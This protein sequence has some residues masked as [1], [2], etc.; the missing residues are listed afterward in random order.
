MIVLGWLICILASLRWRCENFLAQTPQIKC[1]TPN[2]IVKISRT[3]AKYVHH[4]LENETVQLL[5][6]KKYVS[7]RR[8][9]EF[10]WGF[11]L[12]RLEQSFPSKI[13]ERTLITALYKSVFCLFL[14]LGSICLESVWKMNHVVFIRRS[15][16]Q[17]CFFTQPSTRCV[18][19]IR[20]QSFYSR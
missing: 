13:T 2:L 6:L 3:R 14:G 12:W 9:N 5:V 17:E 19:N 16:S 4:F 7:L 8:F 11:L 1:Q 18:R 20:R 15:E 10:S